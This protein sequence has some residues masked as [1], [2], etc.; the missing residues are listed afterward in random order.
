MPKSDMKDEQTHF[1]RD[2]PTSL[3]ITG[4]KHTVYNGSR[5][6]GT[7]YTKIK[8][9]FFFS[10]QMSMGLKQRNG[11]TCEDTKASTA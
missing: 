7:V 4:M 6:N 2:V 10:L 8:E 1:I 5:S 11:I 3:P 9:E